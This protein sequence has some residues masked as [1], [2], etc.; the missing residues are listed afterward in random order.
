MNVQTRFRGATLTLVIGHLILLPLHVY[1]SDLALV[2]QFTPPYDDEQ[3]DY[4]DFAWVHADKLTGRIEAFAGAM[5]EMPL[6]SAT[7]WLSESWS[8]GNAYAAAR[9]DFTVDLYAH[10]AGGA[11]WTTGYIDFA[12]GYELY[13]NGELLGTDVLYWKH[14]DAYPLAW[15]EIDEQ[16]TWSASVLGD[17]LPDETFEIRFIPYVH[18]E[19]GANQVHQLFNV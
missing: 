18:A 15:W 17:V 10:I 7:G 16:V 8:V 5:L 12:C 19:I 14:Y 13:R 2:E 6:C 3:D 9:I 4:G 11:L 1:A